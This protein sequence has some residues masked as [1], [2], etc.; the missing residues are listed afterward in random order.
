M[1]TFNIIIITGL[2]GSG[3]ST[4]LDALEDTGYFCIDNLPV[5]LLKKFLEIRSDS[6]SEVK[7]TALCM[8][9][10]EKDFAE[11]YDSVFRQLRDE[12]YRI[13]IIFLE[14]SDAALIKRYSQ[15]RRQHPIAMGQSLA[16]SIRS[17]R[18][19]LQGLREA[20]DKIIDTSELTVHQL[21]N[22][23]VQYAG[24]DP[25][26]QRM[27][28]GII[29]FGFKHGLPLEADLLID[30]RFLPNPYFVS[31]LRNLTGKDLQVRRFVKKW[32]ETRDF[33]EKYFSLLDFL[34]PLYEKE[35]KSYLTIAI[36]CTGGHHRSVAIAEELSAHLKGLGRSV[37]LTHRDIGL[38]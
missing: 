9:I 31:E 3:K 15:T 6:A 19:M 14:S 37:V 35:G 8:D 1:A 38:V 17:E 4:A 21:R 27:R 20:S 22:A 18:E 29:S 26:F 25:E 36:G 2:S 12:G 32:P 11:K 28:I 34:I 33:L 23:I 10:R 30:V 13:E 7:K 5:L 16:D 24:Q